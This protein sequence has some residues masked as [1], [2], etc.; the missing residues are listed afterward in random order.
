[1]TSW[2]GFFDPEQLKNQLDKLEKDLQNPDLWEDHKK[3]NGLNKEKISLETKV[4]EFDV[5]ASKLADIKELINISLELDEIEELNNQSIALIE[6]N[7][8][9]DALETK[10]YFSRDT[11]TNNAFLDIQSGSGGTE[12]QDWA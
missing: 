6:L 3:L 8:E 11:D 2:G 4:E 7:S 9:I 5:I 12:A 10:K 1:M